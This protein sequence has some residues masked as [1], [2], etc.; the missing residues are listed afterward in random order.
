MNSIH[1]WMINYELL[2]FY[3]T[4]SWIGSW[5]IL[6]Y[7]EQYVVGKDLTDFVKQAWHVRKCKLTNNIL[8]VHNDR[9]YS[10]SISGLLIGKL[11]YRLHISEFISR[12]LIGGLCSRVLI[13][14]LCPRVLIGGLCPRVL[15]GGLCS[16]VLIGGL[17]PR[18]LIGG[19][20]SR[21]LIGWAISWFLGCG[22]SSSLLGQRITWN[23]E[24]K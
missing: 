18:V 14:G 11:L 20:C 16:R 24:T 5:Q 6:V 17:C 7:K 12:V 8:K 1:L 13:S 2:V 9:G 19:L 22:S 3:K 4:N 21:V 23:L 15:I 10:G